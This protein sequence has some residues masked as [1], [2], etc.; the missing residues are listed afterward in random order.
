MGT[1]IHDTLDE[2]YKPYNNKFLTIDHLDQ[3]IQDY[4]RLVTKYF[5]K[6]FKNGDVTTGKNRLAF[7]VSNQ[8]IKRFL[9]M[10]K[11]V[12]QEGHQVKI[13]G[14]EL[15]LETCINIPGIDFPVKIKGIVDRIDEVD[16]V[17]RIIDY[18]TGK[19]NPGDLKVLNF[20]EIKDVKYSKA[21]QVLLYAFLYCQNNS[22][23]KEEALVTGIF[24]FKNLKAGL[25]KI[26]FSS[27]TKNPEHIITKDKLDDFIAQ[28]SLL[29]QE[30]YNPDLAFVAPEKIL[31]H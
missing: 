24:S 16:G 8:F 5:I 17:T 2:L 14:T 10:E 30:I 25:L 1:V 6:H 22:L 19:V 27:K 13:I 9:F 4:K 28:I 12:L 20:E 3:M 21:I 26:N 11:K 18:K 29:L 15:K 23:G 31:Y 7:E